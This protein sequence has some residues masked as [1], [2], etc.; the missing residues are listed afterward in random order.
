MMGIQVASAR[1]FHDFCLDAHVPSDHLPRGINLHLVLDDVRQAL[2]PF[3]SSTARPSIGPELMI[4]MLIVGYCMGM[5]SERGLCEEVHLNL[6][7]R[8][9]V[10][11]DWMG[12][13]RR[14]RTQ[15]PLLPEC[16]RPQDPA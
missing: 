5:R 12:G 13:L 1:I 4:R 14:M 11:P 6:A 16:G 10:V 3:H 15:G 2:K 7:Y 9:F 8:W